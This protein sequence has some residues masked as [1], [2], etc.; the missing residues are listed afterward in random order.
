[1]PHSK[2]RNLSVCADDSTDTKIN[3]QKVMWL[4]YPKNAAPKLKKKNAWPFT[5]SEQNLQFLRP[6][7]FQYFSLKIFFLNN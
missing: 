2:T 5:I 6:M 7:S 3:S 1:M 4:V